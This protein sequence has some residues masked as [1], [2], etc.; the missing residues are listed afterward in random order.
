MYV[1]FCFKYRIGNMS[2]A[3]KIYIEAYAR[4]NT[5]LGIVSFSRYATVLANMTE[6]TS[7]AVRA[8]LSAAVPT[9]A[10]GGTNIGAG[11]AACQTVS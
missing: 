7:P 2:Q 4:D 5:A 10:S 1:V 11:L 3:I 6:I 9:Y 8:S